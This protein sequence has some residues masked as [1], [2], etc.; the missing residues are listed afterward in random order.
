MCAPKIGAS[1]AVC[2]KWR[3]A[4]AQ[5]KQRTKVKEEVSEQVGKHSGGYG[6]RRESIMARMVL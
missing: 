4:G 5:Q 3:G 1:N 2:F 6:Q